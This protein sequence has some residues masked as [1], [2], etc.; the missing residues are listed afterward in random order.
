MYD[1]EKKV[2]NSFLGDS[3]ENNECIKE[4]DGSLIISLPDGSIGLLFFEDRRDFLKGSS[5]HF[6][7][8][9]SNDRNN[10]VISKGNT[11]IV[12]PIEK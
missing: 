7:M 12:Q 3:I 4:M 8:S 6:A 2:T 5:L 1:Q 11:W 10:A 9:K